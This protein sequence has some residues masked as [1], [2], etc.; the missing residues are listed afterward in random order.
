MTILVCKAEI[1]YGASVYMKCG[2]PT[3]FKILF[4]INSF[5]NN[6]D[7][8]HAG[9]AVWYGLHSRSKNSIQSLV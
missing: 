6:Y 4:K 2:Y 1:W 7:N 3:I 9:I 5:P 8:F